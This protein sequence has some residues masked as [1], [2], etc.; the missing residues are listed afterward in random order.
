MNVNA[1]SRNP[2]GQA[3]DDDDFSEEIQD[4]GAMQ[5]DSMDTTGRILSVQYG[6]ESDWFGYKRHS[7]GLTKH[8]K[9]CFGIN[10]WRWLEDH[11][12]FMLDVVTEITQNEEANSLMEDVEVAEN[13]EGQSLGP[14]DGRQS[15][16]KE[17]TRYYDRQQ[18]LELV[19]AAQELSEFGEHGLGQTGSGEE[20]T[21]EMDTRSI[22][23]WKDATCLGLLKG[24]VLPDTIDLE[25]SKRARKRITNY[26]W[27]EERLYF[28]GLYVPKPKE[29]MRLVS[30][31]HEDLG[32]FGEQRT[33]VEICRRYFWHS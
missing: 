22:D 11:Q 5:D 6:K 26:C 32:H 8:H 1:L 16:K 31:M 3:T 12:L 7:K 14:A 30:Q 18:Q 17:M 4:I 23:I 25:E 9:C 28:K 24:G 33:L 21:C 29:R 27:K 2:V 19:L 13:E 10:H 20:E 15:L